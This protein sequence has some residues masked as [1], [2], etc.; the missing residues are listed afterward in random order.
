M[1]QDDFQF[2]FS[3]DLRRNIGIVRC[4]RNISKWVH[5]RHNPLN[6]EIYCGIYSLRTPVA[7]D[8]KQITHRK[9]KPTSTE[10]II[11]I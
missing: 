9:I 3:L 8:R 2:G 5:S 7:S 6:H 10:G 4:S 1:A 11:W